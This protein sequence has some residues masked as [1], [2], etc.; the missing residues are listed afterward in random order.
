[1]SLILRIAA[2]ACFIVAV[3]LAAVS[4]NPDILDILTAESLGMALWVSATLVGE[5]RP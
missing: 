5:A 3:V 4:D 2:L 1:M